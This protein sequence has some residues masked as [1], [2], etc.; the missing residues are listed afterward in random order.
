ME[1]LYLDDA[2]NIFLKEVH[3]A[4]YE[5]MSDWSFKNLLE[6]IGYMLPKKVSVDELIVI[7]KIVLNDIRNKVCSF[8]SSKTFKDKFDKIIE[9][10]CNIDILLTYIPDFAI[11]AMPE[12]FASEFVVM[13][14]KAF[15]GLDNEKGKDYGCVELEPNVIDISHKDKAEVL[16]SL[17]NH[18]KPIGMG[19]VQFDPRPM[20]VEVARMILNT[21]GYQFS[22]LKGRTMKINL[23]EDTVYV[24]RYNAD[25]N[26]P[27]LAQK[28]I[29][30][31]KDIERSSEALGR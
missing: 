5:G 28:A 22:Y 18:S 10:K 31:C 30:A 27:G 2:K 7:I 6:M 3:E 19:I 20:S 21:M 29:S 24:G 26:Q 4:V 25:N 11:A 9:D 15:F 12:D 1:K 23:S 17:Y 8:P 13:F 14:R 16:A